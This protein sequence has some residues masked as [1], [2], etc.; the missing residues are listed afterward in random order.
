MCP[1]PVGER[2]LKTTTH[3]AGKRARAI[4]NG[5][6]RTIRCTELSDD[7]RRDGSKRGTKKP[8]DRAVRPQAGSARGRPGDDDD[9]YGRRTDA[10]VCV[11]HAAANDDP[12]G[13]GTDGRRRRPVRRRVRPVDGPLE[14]LHRPDGEQRRPDDLSGAA[15]W[16]RNYWR[17]WLQSAVGGR[18]HHRSH[19][20]RHQTHH[21]HM[22]T[23]SCC[24]W[25][26]VLYA[27]IVVVASFARAAHS[28]KDGK[29]PYLPIKHA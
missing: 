14:N 26:L 10:R 3:G 5:G 8:P 20:H 7:R 6:R 21:L 29:Y 17:P 11:C 23:S 22:W 15:K 13:T 24:W 28:A 9:G 27:A 19:W 12:T 1:D 18:Q 4:F 16:F 2:Q 25:L